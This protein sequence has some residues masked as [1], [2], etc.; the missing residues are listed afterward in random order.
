MAL[1]D[2]KT[3]TQN[4]EILLKLFTSTKETFGRLRMKIE[5]T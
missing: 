4:S 2:M 3:F 1:R 5:D